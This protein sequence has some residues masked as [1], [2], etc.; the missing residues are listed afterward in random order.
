MATTRRNCTTKKD[1][2]K[3]VHQHE[4]KMHKGKKVTKIKIGK[5]K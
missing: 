4:Y 5:G 3:A 1:V 2:A